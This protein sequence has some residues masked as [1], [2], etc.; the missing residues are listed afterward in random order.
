[1]SGD[2][3][4]GNSESAALRWKGKEARGLLWFSGVINEGMDDGDVVRCRGKCAAERGH[5]SVVHIRCAGIQQNNPWAHMCRV[6]PKTS[7]KYIY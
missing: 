5:L 1:M 7:L 6:P 4:D 2:C 3:K